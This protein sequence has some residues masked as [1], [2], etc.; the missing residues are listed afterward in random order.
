MALTAT[1]LDLTVEGVPFLDDV[2]FQLERGRLYTVLGR[3]GA[4][5]TTLL[6]VVAGLQ[7]LDGGT[8]TM[9]GQDLAERPVWKR[10]TAMVYQ[11]FINYPH[12]TVRDNV[13]FPL[14]RAGL[15]KTEVTQRTGEY[16]EK[17]GLSGFAD[18]KPGQLSGGQQQRVAL[19]RA[20]ARKSSVLLLDEPLVNLDYKLREQ[21]REE[22]KELFSDQG[23]AVVIYT[24]TEP[25]EA[26]MLGDWLLVMDEGRVIQQGTPQEVFD[27]PLTTAVTQIINDPPMNIIAGELRG[28][29]VRLPGGQ[30]LGA[31]TH[32]ADLPDG[33]YQF[34]VRATDLRPGAGASLAGRMSYVEVSGSETLVHVDTPAAPLIVQIDGIH[35]FQ[36]GDSMSLEVDTSQVFVFDLAGLR[37]RSPDRQG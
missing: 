2:S 13:A 32:L 5:K 35:A 15:P 30:A 33:A 23:S 25:A 12:L 28:G 16:L 26:V 24:T 36:T 14:R 11:Q 3:T 20:L 37:L 21:L 6:R 27:S 22:V 8:L 10:D 18:R 19:A 9:D 4:G 34:G 29:Q 31:A 1:A 7:P 17:V